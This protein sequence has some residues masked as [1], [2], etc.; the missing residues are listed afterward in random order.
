MG[1]GGRRALAAGA[2][3]AGAGVA[4][5]GSLAWACT[6]L[7]TLSSSSTAARPGEQVEIVGRGYDGNEEVSVRFD[8]REGEV[9][10][11]AQPDGQ[12]AFRASVAVPPLRP[13]VHALVATQADATG[14][15]VTATASLPL[16]IGGE[17]VGAPVAGPGGSAAL[18]RGRGE[19]TASTPAAPPWLLFGSLGLAATVLMV[20]GAASLA[21]QTSTSPATARLTAPPSRTW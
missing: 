14:A 2:V 20:A 5:T 4:L 11:T 6:S 3:A 18:A 1:L 21:A 12:G 7:A 13:G 16:R 8:S 9:V 17:P 15:V 10:A 19:D